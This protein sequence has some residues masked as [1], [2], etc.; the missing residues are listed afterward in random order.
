MG[1]RKTTWTVGISIFGLYLFMYI[2]Y[3]IFVIFVEGEE[4]ILQK[5]DYFFCFIY[6]TSTACYSTNKQ[7]EERR[8]GNQFSCANKTNK[9]TILCRGTFFPSPLSFPKGK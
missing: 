6:S 3:I 1:E 4:E 5:T 9:I 2:R 8:G 7:R